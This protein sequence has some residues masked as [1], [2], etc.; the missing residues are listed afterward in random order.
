MSIHIRNK[1]PKT[2]IVLGAPH[3]GTSFV[4]K[5]LEDGGVDMGVDMR[6]F[7]QDTGFV[8]INRRILRQAGGDPYD[9]PTEEEILAVDQSSYL[10]RL[11]DRRKKGKKFWGWKDPSTSLTA[12]HYFPHLEGDPY[13]I[14]IFRKPQTIVKS[15]KNKE[16]GRIT[17]KLIDRY[18]KSII[19]AIKKFCE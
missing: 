17:R 2:Y 9:P 19:S 1:E 14:C 11:I 16:K 7:Y 12:Q 13:L 18:N 4:A 3:S 15:Y 8:G 5:M 6:S 10:R